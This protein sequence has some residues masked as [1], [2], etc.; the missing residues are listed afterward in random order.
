VRPKNVFNICCKFLDSRFGQIDLSG[1]PICLKQPSDD[2]ELPDPKFAVLDNRGSSSGAAALMRGI[3]ELAHDPAVQEQ[4]ARETGDPA[5][6]AD[7]QQHQAENVAR[8]FRRLNPS[9]YRSPENWEAL[10]HA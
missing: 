1:C 10:V 9:Y 4:I 5:L 8:E 6:L 2:D 7:Y 3:E